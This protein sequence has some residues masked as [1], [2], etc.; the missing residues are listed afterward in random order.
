MIS[1][2][3]NSHKLCAVCWD[4][5]EYECMSVEAFPTIGKDLFFEEK[6]EGLCAHRS[7]VVIE[8]F[9]GMA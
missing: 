8:L 5:S 7:E 2:M 6:G 4:R 1:V 3:N 9:T